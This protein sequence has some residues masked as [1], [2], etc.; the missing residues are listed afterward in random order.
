MK[1]MNAKGRTWTV[2]AEH[3]EEHQYPVHMLQCGD[4]LAVSYGADFRSFPMHE[5]LAA[6]REFGYSV[7]HSIACNGKLDDYSEAA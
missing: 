1:T 5:D 2:L 3:H 4:E 6:F 7:R